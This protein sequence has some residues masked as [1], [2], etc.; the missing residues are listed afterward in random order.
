MFYFALPSVKILSV[1]VSSVEEG[2]TNNVAA[3]TDMMP[4]FGAAVFQQF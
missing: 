1:R 3:R 2:E 4:N